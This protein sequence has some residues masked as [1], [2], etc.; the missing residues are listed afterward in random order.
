[1]KPMMSSERMDWGTPDWLFEKLD[2]IFGFDLDTACTKENAMCFNYLTEDNDGLKSEWTTDGMAWCNPPYN[3][4][5]VVWIKK[6]LEE[7]SKGNPSVLLVKSSTGVGWFQYVWKADAIV[8]IK[9]RLKFKGAET[10]APFDSVIAVFGRGL[11]KVEI[12][13]LSEIGKVIIP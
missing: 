10:G 7:A 4:G 1:M 11:S 12:E 6:A 3:R 13:E 5:I 8:F 2:N 9:G